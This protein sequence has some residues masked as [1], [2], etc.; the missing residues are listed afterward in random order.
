[1]HS[2][3]A[4]SLIF[5][6]FFLFTGESTV[7]W[8]EA[9]RIISAGNILVRKMSKTN[10]FPLQSIYLIAKSEFEF[11]IRKD[12]RLSIVDGFSLRIDGLQEKDAGDYICE[13]ETYGKPVSQTSTLEILGERK[14]LNA[15][16]NYLWEMKKQFSWHPLNAVC[17]PQSFVSLKCCKIFAK[18]RV[19]RM[20]ISVHCN[21]PR[22]ALTFHPSS[23]DTTFATSATSR[24]NLVRRPPPQTPKKRK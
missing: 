8:K 22:N 2:F 6:S 19:Y 16:L 21:I 1:M 15:I 7:I 17:I 12:R 11:Q 18:L 9:E 10:V 23:F 4:F 5:W 14:N 3:L 24:N 13:I 20:F